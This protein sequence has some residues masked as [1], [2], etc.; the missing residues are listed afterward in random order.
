M[1][2]LDQTRKIIK[3]EYGLLWL[4]RKKKK[5]KEPKLVNFYD[6]ELKERPSLEEL[7]QMGLPQVHR[8]QYTPKNGGRIRA[9]CSRQN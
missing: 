7:E 8:K 4:D 5:K 6:Y 2:L 3:L 9:S 1:D